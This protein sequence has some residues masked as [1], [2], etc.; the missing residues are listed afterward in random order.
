MKEVGT[1]TEL[2]RWLKR[3]SN[4]EVAVLAGDRWEK[5]I[6]G[7]PESLIS[8]KNNRLIR[9]RDGAV[10]F[11][12]SFDDWDSWGSN[13]IVQVGD[14]FLYNGKRILCQGV[15]FDEWRAHP[16]GLIGRKDNKLLLNGETILF[17]V[18]GRECYYSWCSHPNSVIIQNE[19]TLLVVWR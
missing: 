3:A 1:P 18:E 8:Q 16:L 14:T 10:L 17:E 13:F 2:Q 4:G 12:G 11:S 15:S 7:R 5:E 9:K 19:R 6:W